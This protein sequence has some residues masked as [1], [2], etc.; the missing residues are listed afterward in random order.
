M[1]K[2]SSEKCRVLI[3][4][5][6]QKIR[7]LLT[8]LIEGEGYEVACACDGA[9]GLEIVSSFEPDVV[10]SDVVMPILDGIQFCRR[11]KQEQKTADIPVLL[12]SGLRNTAEDSIEGLTAGADDYLEIPFRNG[13]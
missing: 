3:V 10:I 1:I 4:D 8:E 9:S 12:I 2:A 6:D 11:I 13:E 5:D 7:M